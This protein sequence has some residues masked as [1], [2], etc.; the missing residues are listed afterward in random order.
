MLDAAL[1]TLRARPAFPLFERMTA[2]PAARM[3]EEIVAV[4][5]VKPSIVPREDRT[6]T[7][8]AQ[9]EVPPVLEARSATKRNLQTPPPS[10]EIDLALRRHLAR[11]NLEL[12]DLEL[13]AAV[14]PQ[15]ARLRAARSDGDGREIERLLI[16]LGPAIDA[17]PLTPAL[18]DKKLD[19]AHR[20]LS[21]LRASLEPARYERLETKYLDAKGE[22]LRTPAGELEAYWA[23]L[24][25]L[26]REIERAKHP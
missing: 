13:L 24:S 23:K 9:P 16:E 25:G 10:K 21:E 7:V 17:A 11:R 5:A 22:L 19:R 4:P 26:L 8:E 2:E 3:H 1:Q 15:V 20:T 12:D 18:I 6:A 14:R